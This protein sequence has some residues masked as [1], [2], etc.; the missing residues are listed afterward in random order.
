MTPKT[1]P[2]GVPILKDIITLIKALVSGV[3]DAEEEFLEYLD[4]FSAFEGTVHGLTDK[5]AADFPGLAL[6]NA[7]LLIRESGKRKSS[8]TVQRSRQRTLISSAGDITFTHTLYKDKKG[9]LRCLL[10]EQLRLPDRERFTPVA[11]ANV[12]KEAEAHSYQHAA[13]SIK[14]NGQT[15]TKTT[16]MNKVHSIE[17]EIPEMEELPKEK[18]ACEY[19]YIEA[20]EDHI[21]R[22]KDRKKQGCF[23]GKLVY[24]FEGKEEAGNGRR[25]LVSPF[26]FGGLYAGTAQ[27]AALWEEVDTYIQEHYDQ[28]ALKCVYIN[29]DG[30][31]WIRAAV[32][33]NYVGKSKLVADRFHLMKYIN[34]V[35][36]YTLDEENLTKGRFYKYIYKNKLLEAKKLLTRLKNHYAGSERAVEE[37]WT[38]LTGNWNSIQRSLHDRHVLGCSAE[39]HV[40]SVYSERMSSRPMG[41]SEI[42]SDRMCR[43]RCFIRNYRREKIV[44]LVNYCRER[45]LSAMG[46]TGTDGMID[47]PQRKRYTQK[48]KEAQ[49]YAEA[50]HGTISR[51]S[52]V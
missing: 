50:L 41:W 11:E 12:L 26:Y 33:L 38:Y 24:L 17:K 8:Y 44:D 15:I 19:L 40:S 48:Q 47:K 35:A 23:M 29:S 45:E 51:N 27:N 52:T 46:I 31:S 2:K 7:D 20:D 34:R 25:K 22:Q 18:K 16:V 30:A 14:T 43:L 39:G 9:K 4:T 5:M 13:E 6:T 1:K 32:N 21:H 49:R 3:L 28:D 37:C 42:G 36:R 10:D